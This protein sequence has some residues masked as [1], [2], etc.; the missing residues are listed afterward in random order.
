MELI[1]WYWVAYVS[2]IIVRNYRSADCPEAP[3][4]DSIDMLIIINVLMHS[5]R[6]KICLNINVVQTGIFWMYC[7]SCY[8][9]TTL[10]NCSREWQIVYDP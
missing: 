2:L 10:C 9:V 1:D 6:L 8:A 3:F 5:C 7:Q 4:P